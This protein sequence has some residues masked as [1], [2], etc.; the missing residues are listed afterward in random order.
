VQASL[1]VFGLLQSAEAAAFELRLESDDELRAFVDKLDETS[2][3][4]ADSAPPR[5]VPSELRERVLSQAGHGRKVVALPRS[6][7]IPWSLAACLAL[8]CAYLVAESGGLRKRITRLKKR[9]ILARVQIASLSSKLAEAPNANAMV[10]WD[11]KKQRGVLKVMQLPRNAD[12]HD[13]QLWLVDPRYKDPVN[14]G[15]FH[16]AKDG[17]LSVQFHPN[18]PVREAR[19]FAISVERKG[20]VTKA[21]GPIVL[22]GK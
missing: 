13:Y 10:V 5:P 9:D 1:Y 6:V 20:G 4:I 18:A 19:A 12:D 11:E 15:A 17:S 21:E 14:G 7:W 2:A 3:M 22:A 16:V 8:T